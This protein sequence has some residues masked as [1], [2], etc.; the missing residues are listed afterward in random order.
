[1]KKYLALFLACV[2]LALPAAAQSIVSGA[3]S[4]RTY[5]LTSLTA[6]TNAQLLTVNASTNLLL[7][8]AA[9]HNIAVFTSV[10]ATNTGVGTNATGSGAATF[11]NY[12]DLGKVVGSVT[13]WT[14]TQPI[15]VTG[16]LNGVTP[17]VSYSTITPTQFDGADF[18]R[19]TYVGHSATNTFYYSVTLG[20]TP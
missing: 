16:T 17:V 5:T 13:N 8:A 15:K 7:T 4:P 2:A 18:I 6:V 11:T 14:T 12:F 1:M 3:V 10:N 20:Q 9:Q 19:L